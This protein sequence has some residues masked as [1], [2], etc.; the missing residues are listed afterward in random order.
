[1]IALS[2]LAAVTIAFPKAGRHFPYQE[3]CYMIGATSG[4]ET[5]L[6]I[7]GKNVSVYKNGGWVTM[8][9]C[10]EG[11]N[12]VDVAGIRHWFVIGRKPVRRA[13]ATTNAAPSKV[14]K[15]LDYAGDVPRPH[16]ASLAIRP[17]PS[18]MTI[19]LDAGH[20]GSDSG[21]L[22]PHAL[23]EKDANLRMAKAVQA[24]LVRKG[25]SVVMTR[26]KDKAVKL[27][28]RPKSAHATNAVAFVSI[29]HNAPPTDKDPR[30]F[31]YHAVYAWNDIGVRLASA[32]NRRMAESFGTSLT[33]NGVP[34][35]NF[36]VTR[37][38]EIPSCLIEVDFITTP[39]GEEACWNPERRKLVATAIADGIVDWCTTPEKAADQP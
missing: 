4:G 10:T 38:P 9:D 31:R 21:A 20:G 39:E 2:L 14:W 15:K 24:E 28:D 19:V 7:Q 5:N 27:Y 3:R 13:G 25:Y 35:A 17:D 12:W 6:V 18:Q 33:N 32:I 23:P 11:T 8:L 34:H 22:S 29:H 26:T 1:M 16:P 36:A 37:N 30:T